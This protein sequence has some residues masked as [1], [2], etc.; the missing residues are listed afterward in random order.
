MNTKGM[1]AT[2]NNFFSSSL[3]DGILVVRQKQHI[4]KVTQDLDHI[5]SFY[6]YLDSLLS[7]KSFKAFVMLAFSGQS[8]RLE[9]SRFLTKILSVNLRGNDL[10]RYFNVVNRL[11]VTLSTL[12]CMT[13]FAGQG[14]ISTFYLNIGLAHDY[15]IV[16]DDTVFENLNEDTGLITK[17]SGYFLPRLI[18]IRK[19][20]DVLQWKSFT[21][22]DALQMGLVDLIVPVSQLEE[23]T[24][25]FMRKALV[26]SSSTLVGI[27]RLLKCDIKELKRSLDLEDRLIKER[28]NSE[29]FRK[30]FS[31]GKS[32]SQRLTG[33]LHDKEGR[34]GSRDAA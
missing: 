16:S 3:D 4:L 28:L 20:S 23:E 33:S 9:Y 19:A 11:I 25:K 8:G 6:A 5:F 34:S 14:T 31:S 12:N 30:M 17:G 21:A 29:E 27:R 2:D 10:D 22:E 24:M 15:R 1:L 13:V 32:L 18:G 26:H 7:S